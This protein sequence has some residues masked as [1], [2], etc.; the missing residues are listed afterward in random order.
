MSLEDIKRNISEAKKLTNGL[1]D[2]DEKIKY[3][4]G[5]KKDF[6]V[7]AMN[8]MFE[9]LKL[10]NKAIPDSTKDISAVKKLVSNS[11]LITSQK[12]E[13]T[14]FK[15]SLGA[16]Q[17]RVVS[18]KRE[19][20]EKYLKELSLSESHL[21]RAGGVSISDNS[22][23]PNIIA[24]IASSM[25]GGIAESMGNAVPD[26]KQDLKESNSRFLISTYIAIAIFSSLSVF[27]LSILLLVLLF[28]SGVS[29][30]MYAW[31]PLF[32]LFVSFV[33]FYMYPAA[34]KSSINKEISTEL[35]FAAIYMSAIAGSNIE[36]T[37]I[38]KIIA[39]SQEYRYVGVEMRKIINQIEIYGYDLVNSLKNVA[40][41]TINKKL[42]ELLN[43]MATNIATGSSL[44]NYLE[45][46]SQNLLDDYKMER[47]RYNDVAST[48]MDVYISVLITAPLILVMLIVIMSLTNLKFGSFSTDSM[49][50]FSI[51]LVAIVN[52]IFLVFLQVK[53]PKV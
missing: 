44:Q 39:D 5:S 20:R 38:F 27:V 21:K 7:S 9:R 51:A 26:L 50:T 31:V 33:G 11:S 15:Y 4:S 1:K 3:A 32:L 34:R 52:V 45:K 25:F 2:L 16:G 18:L 40:K 30:L 46:K 23:R 48:F 53:Q 35:P 10:I 12:K 29:V 37:K 13:V 28:V 22:V 43:G 8:S 6:L 19:D 42:A 14:N 49:L 17:D 36:P 41:N 47:N 24:K